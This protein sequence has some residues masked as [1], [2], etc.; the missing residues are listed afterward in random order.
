[1]ESSHGPLARDFEISVQSQLNATHC[2]GSYGK[3]TGE[4]LPALCYSTYQYAG[5]IDFT[6]YGEK[7]RHYLS[8]DQFPESLTLSRTLMLL[9][10]QIFG[11]N[12]HIGQCGTKTTTAITLCG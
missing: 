12:L 3:I 1:M 6:V 10:G 2:Q 7:K 4:H 5:N 11:E 9:L 8:L